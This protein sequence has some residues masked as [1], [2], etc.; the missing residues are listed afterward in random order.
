MTVKEMK[1]TGFWRNDPNIQPGWH[2][3]KVSAVAVS[4]EGSCCS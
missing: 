2:V 1:T 3:V 4:E